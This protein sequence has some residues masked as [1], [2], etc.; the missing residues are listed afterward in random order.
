MPLP[1]EQVGS[2]PRPPELIDAVRAAAAGKLAENELAPLYE[3]ALRETVEQLEATGSPVI[4]DGE[5]TKPSFATYPLVGLENHAP[6]G[7]EIPFEDGHVRQLPR[8]TGG[9][10]RYAFMPTLTLH[11]RSSSQVFR[12]SRR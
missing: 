1:T 4:T 5:Q 3:S 6:D 12:S 7:V 10:F 11:R 8:L 9:P 2:I